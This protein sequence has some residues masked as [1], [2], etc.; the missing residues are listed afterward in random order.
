[1]IYNKRMTNW[2]V[3]GSNIYYKDKEV[4][5]RGT[6]LFGFECTDLVLKGLDH[7]SMYDLIHNV[8]KLGFNA[9]RVPFSLETIWRWNDIA[10]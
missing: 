8:K 7:H 2:R 1:M 4:K 9:I 6:N 5:I 3:Q 10:R